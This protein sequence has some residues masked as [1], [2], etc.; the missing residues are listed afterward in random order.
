M[1]KGRICIESGNRFR[2][3]HQ[4]DS[5]FI[6]IGISISRH[7]RNTFIRVLVQKEGEVEL[8]EIDLKFIEAI[9]DQPD[10]VLDNTER[11]MEDA[12]RGRHVAKVVAQSKGVLN[13]FSEE[14]II[15][16]SS[17]KKQV[18]CLNHLILFNT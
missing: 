17:R 18:K 6:V 14:I 15:G 10:R 5:V 11:G 7:S 9:W 1:K 3:E 16:P 2:P 12:I 13:P 8:R 4:S